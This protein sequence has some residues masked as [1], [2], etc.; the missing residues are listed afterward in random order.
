[1]KQVSLSK[2]DLDVLWKEYKEE[3]NAEAKD[4]LVIHY[5][6]LVKY[7]AGRIAIHS[8]SHVEEDDLIAWG[9]LGL[10]DAAEKFD[11]RQKTSF[12]TYAS[13]RIRGAILDHIRS[14]DWAPRSLRRKSRQ[15]AEV[16]SR[17]KK[18]LGREP[19]GIELASQLEISEHELFELQADIHGAYI[20]S[21]DSMISG[22]D[23]ENETT[24]AE[25]T[26]ASTTPSP[27]ESAARKEAEQQLAEAI[28]RLPEQ[29]RQVVTLYY[30]DEL[31]LKEIGETLGLSESRICQVHRTVIRK[32]QKSLQIGL[33]D[34]FH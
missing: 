2:K 34:V 16:H 23:A 19:T 27:E 10:L 22:E 18:E 6:G 29:E 26:T 32:L 9:V 8:P 12:E 31:T 13:T 17:L 20:I 4:A 3:H 1:M 7:L 33:R 21:L 14:L 15:L 5:L 25:V 24:L 28:E 30:Y 11:H